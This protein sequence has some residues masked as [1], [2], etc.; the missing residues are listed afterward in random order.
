MKL[1]GELSRKLSG[2]LRR[3]SGD[4]SL[5][6]S[7]IGTAFGGKSDEFTCVFL[8]KLHDR[9]ISPQSGEGAMHEVSRLRT[10][11]VRGFREPVQEQAKAR[12]TNTARTPIAK[13]IWGIKIDCWL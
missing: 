12:I 8:S 4:S 6:Q 1:S 2:A 13:A 3:P 7:G 10:K 5:G 9:P 11:V